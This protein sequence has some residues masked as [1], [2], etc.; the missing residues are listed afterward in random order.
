M[1]FEERTSTYR[2]LSMLRLSSRRSQGLVSSMSTVLYDDFWLKVEDRSNR[3][4][5]FGATLTDLV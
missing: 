1:L 3:H 2:A 5:K 4:K